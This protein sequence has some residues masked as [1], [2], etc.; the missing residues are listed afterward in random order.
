MLVDVSVVPENFRGYG[1]PI[2]ATVSILIFHREDDARSVDEALVFLQSV[3]TLAKEGTRRRKEGSADEEEG[4]RY[5]CRELT[6]K[7]ERKRE[8][9][10]D[11]LNNVAWRQQRSVKQL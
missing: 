9:E 1:V 6:L 10:N 8:R 4:L 2:V 5:R 11:S 3:H 7:T